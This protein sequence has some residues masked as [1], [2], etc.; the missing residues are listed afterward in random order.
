MGEGR[1]RGRHSGGVSRVARL[2]FH[3]APFREWRL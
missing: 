3:N 1:A 2:K